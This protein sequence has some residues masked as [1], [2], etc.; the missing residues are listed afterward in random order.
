M[1]KLLLTVDLR[2]TLRSRLA[3]ASHT[4][5]RESSHGNERPALRP[6]HRQGPGVRAADP[7]APPRGR[8][9][10]VSRG[11]GDDEVEL[12]ALRLQG[13]ALPHGCV[14]AALRLRLLEGRAGS[15]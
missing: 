12:S 9:R 8:A 10:G 15:R 2:S 7:G 11:Q 1:S 6:V 4:L 14:Q 3:V 13:A 5:A